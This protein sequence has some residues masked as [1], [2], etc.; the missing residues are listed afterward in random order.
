[1][2]LLLILS[3]VALIPQAQAKQKSFN[4]VKRDIIKSSDQRIKKLNPKKHSKEKIAHEKSFN[5]CAKNSYTKKSMLKCVKDRMAF[6]DK[7]KARLNA[8]RKKI[9]A[10][11]RNLFITSKAKALKRAKAS[12]HASPKYVVCLEAAKEIPS[13]RKCMDEEIKVQ[14]KK[15]ETLKKL[16]EKINK[17]SN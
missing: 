8:K 7:E 14:R 4:E 2:K 9:E 1:M 12:K 13:L 3:M 11:K 17:K 5:K 16:Q 6:L 15:Q 10:K